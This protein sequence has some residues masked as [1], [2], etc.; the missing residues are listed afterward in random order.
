MENKKTR[1][2]VLFNIDPETHKAIKIRATLRGMSLTGWI[3]SAIAS[4][5]KQEQ[6]YE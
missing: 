4:K 5:I 1:K 2:R 3:M 6:K